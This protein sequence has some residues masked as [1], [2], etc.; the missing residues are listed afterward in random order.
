MEEGRRARPPP[1]TPRR[2]TCRRGRRPGQPVE[3]QPRR[4]GS[5]RRRRTAPRPRQC[6][7]ASPSWSDSSSPSKVTF[8]TPGVPFASTT[9]TTNEQNPWSEVGTGVSRHSSSSS[10]VSRGSRSS[11]VGP[12]S[13]SSC[14]ASSPGGM[15]TGTPQPR[16][17]T[18][19]ETRSSRGRTTPSEHGRILVLSDNPIAARDPRHRLHRGAHR[20][21]WGRPTTAVRAWRPL[22]PQRDAVVLCDHDAPDAPGV[23]RDALASDGRL[24]R[25][26]G[27]PT[28]C[29]GTASTTSA[30]GTRG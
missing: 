1:R 8:E 4:C 28:P 16:V 25:D 5:A 17:A 12:S 27:E 13:P 30:P 18:H 22:R 3:Q 6:W 19:D 2:P 15:A 14:W 23:L 21:W 26:D 29:R 7:S 11:S 10:A 20:S 24:R 9:G